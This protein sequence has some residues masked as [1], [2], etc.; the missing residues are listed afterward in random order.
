[1]QVHLAST[2]QIKIDAVESCFPFGEVH[3]YK[4]CPSQVNDQPMSFAE[5]TR[6]CQNRLKNLLGM[7]AQNEHSD[8]IF[9]A[10]ENFIFRVDDTYHDMAV[11]MMSRGSKVITTYSPSVEIPSKYI[12]YTSISVTAASRM[13]VD[14]P[15][16]SVKDPHLM[17]CG[18]GG[19]RQV[20]LESTIKIGMTQ[21]N[22]D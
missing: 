11:V 15:N 18:E 22:L 4:N 8:D 21:L 7:Y 20:F 16:I 19:K 2:S 3:K 1:M 13:S 9:I 5:G 17:I 10:I 12:D 6:G 14:Y